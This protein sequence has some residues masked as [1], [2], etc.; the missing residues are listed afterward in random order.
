MCVILSII[1]FTSSCAAGRGEGCENVIFFDDVH[2]GADLE[3]GVKNDRIKKRINRINGSEPEISGQVFFLSISL[4]E[5]YKNNL[6]SKLI[7]LWVIPNYGKVGEGPL[8]E[9]VLGD[10]GKVVC[11]ESLNDKFSASVIFGSVQ[12]ENY[13]EILSK[14]TEIVTDL[15]N[16]VLCE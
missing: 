6:H 10:S 4:L 12:G 5:S 3:L 9:A 2:G 15:K 11:G 8:C 14:T 1:G 13:E 16:N 7:D